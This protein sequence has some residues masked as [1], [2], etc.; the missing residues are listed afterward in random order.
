MIVLHPACKQC[1][2]P[3]EGGVRALYCQS[4]LKKRAKGQ[5]GPLPD[6]ERFCLVGGPYLAPDVRPGDWLEDAERGSVQVGGYTQ[7]ARIPWPRLKKTGRASLILCGDLIRAIQTESALAIGYWW[8]VSGF[9]IARWRKVLGI[10]QV[11]TEGSLRLYQKYTSQ[12]LPEDV[13][14]R[15]RKNA[16]SP[17]SKA[18]R[19]A[20]ISGKPVSPAVREALLNAAKRP[21]SEEWKEKQRENMLQQWQDGYRNRTPVWTP[22]ADAR[23]LALHQRGLTAREIAQKMKKTHNS[24]LSRLY[25]LRKRLA[26][27]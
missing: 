16:L 27:G 26:T 12:K 21:K 23:L 17:E 25:F 20:A 1:G 15:G 3:F 13:A 8:G 24:I 22:K 7:T 10:D 18:R 4:C 2:E 9:V 11:G 14:A 19:S 5:T 6:D